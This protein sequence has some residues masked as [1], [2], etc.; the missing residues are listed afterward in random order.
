MHGLASFEAETK[1]ATEAAAQR[2][3]REAWDLR[4]RRRREKGFRGLEVL[5]FGF[6]AFKCTGF[7]FRVLGLGFRGL[8]VLGLGFRV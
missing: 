6:R 4:V 5:G 2:Q 1:T 8:E 3:H 7:G